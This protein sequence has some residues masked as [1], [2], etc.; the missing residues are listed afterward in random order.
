MNDNTLVAICGYSGD[1][2]LIRKF[3]P[4]HE[5]HEC[6][7]VVLSPMDAPVT[8]LR[9][10]ICRQAGL[11]AYIGQASLTRQIEYFKILLEYPHDFY[12]IND[13]DSFC[14]SAQIPQEWRR[15][16]V[17]VNRVTDPRTHESK[18]PRYAFQPPYHCTREHLQNFIDVA[19]L[20]PAHPITPYVDH[21]MV[22]LIYEAGLD[23]VAFTE[24]EHPAPAGVLPFVGADPWKQL[25]YRI[26]YHGAVAMHP[27]K[28]LSQSALIKRARRFYELTHT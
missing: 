9:K 13:S 17:W 20:C 6:P 10:H 26:K 2:H 11:R 1:A 19:H 25:E 4:F 18:Y 21:F 14:A 5:Q 27:I 7:I 15:G 28:N 3:M 8:K 12:L 22:Q 16:G 23:H 24:L